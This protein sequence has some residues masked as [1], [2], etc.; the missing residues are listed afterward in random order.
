MVH[1]ALLHL[2]LWMVHCV[3]PFILTTL[4][5]SRCGNAFKHTKVSHLDHWLDNRLLRMFLRAEIRILWQSLR[6][7]IDLLKAEAQAL[8][9]S[10]KDAED[11]RREVKLLNAENDK[12]KDQLQQ[13]REGMAMADNSGYGKN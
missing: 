6:D 7:D 11:L 13:L 5:N 2:L 3:Q 1:C 12:L 8:R 4:L 9:M 10:A